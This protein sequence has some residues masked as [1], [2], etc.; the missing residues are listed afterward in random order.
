M[1]T[2]TLDNPEIEKKYTPYE[3]KLKFLNF[4]E[5]E[6]KEDK[7]ELYEIS[8]EDLP[9]NVLNSYNNINNI[10]FIKR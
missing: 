9:E 7:V 2:I 6:L 3:I 8:V 4:L 1:T 5:T 10:K